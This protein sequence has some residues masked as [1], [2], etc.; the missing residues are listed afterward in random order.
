VDADAD[1]QRLAL[2]RLVR[3]PALNRD[4]CLHR[5]DHA[6][7]GGEQRVAGHRLGAAVAVAD[8]PLRDRLQVIDRARRALV[9]LAHQFAE[10]GHIGQQHGA[11]AAREGVVGFHLWSTA[12]RSVRPA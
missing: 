7:E 4:R 3:E 9:V 10:T 6:V 8:D 1:L 12:A 2:E 5:R 11:H